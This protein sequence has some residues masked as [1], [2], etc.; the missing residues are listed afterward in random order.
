MEEVKGDLQVR[1][2]QWVTARAEADIPQN[3]TDIFA[4]K[5]FQIVS[6]GSTSHP[7]EFLQS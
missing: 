6:E 1:T 2:V 3:D 7:K 5:L 4:A